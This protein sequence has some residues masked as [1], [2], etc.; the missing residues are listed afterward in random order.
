MPEVLD[1]AQPIAACSAPGSH[2]HDADVQS[3][4]ELLVQEVL[5]PFFVLLAKN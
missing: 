5:L 3:S 1:A 4:G 2:S